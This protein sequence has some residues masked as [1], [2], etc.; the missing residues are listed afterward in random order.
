VF[1]GERNEGGYTW[2]V[3]E[4][5]PSKRAKGVI[6]IMRGKKGQRWPEKKIHEAKV[7]SNKSNEGLLVPG[8]V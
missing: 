6:E 1:L 7:T 5:E 4:P 2:G 3:I 8:E